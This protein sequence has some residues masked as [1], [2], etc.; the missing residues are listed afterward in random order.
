MATLEGGAHD[1]PNGKIGNLIYSR[2]RGSDG[3]IATVRSYTKPS[4][5]KTADQTSQRDK[6]SYCVDTVKKIGSSIYEED[7]DR[8]VKNLAGFQSLVQVLLEKMSSDGQLSSPDPVNLGSLDA[9]T[10]PTVS[11]DYTNDGIDITWD[12]AT[13]PDTGSSDDQINALAIG[14]TVDSEDNRIID[15]FR[16]EA[17]RSA[18]TAS[19]SV[20][21]AMSEA[22]V[23]F[24]VRGA[25]D[26]EGMLSEA[27]S[28][29]A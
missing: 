19:L 22:V 6:F 4:N 14:T 20:D 13:S 17:L 5:P 15:V 27:Q 10:N 12:T 18:G 26:Y 2:A 9:L 29:I 7:F 11:A 28:V 16:N 21:T 8:S 24:Y 1:A 23:M 25:G 3:S